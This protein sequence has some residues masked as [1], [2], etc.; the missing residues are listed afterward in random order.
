MER[1]PDLP[2]DLPPQFYEGLAEHNAETATQLET[3][4]KSAKKVIRTALGISTICVATT[5]A[6]SFLFREAGIPVLC[7]AIPGVITTALSVYAGMGE[8]RQR[9]MTAVEM[10]N[11]LKLATQRTYEAQDARNR[12]RIF[13]IVFRRGPPTTPPFLN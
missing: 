11:R 1:H 13:K 8:I 3:E 2:P 5:I 7:C 10:N 12:N 6:G 4:V 9:Q